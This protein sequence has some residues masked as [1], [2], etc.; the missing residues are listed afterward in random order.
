MSGIGLAIL[1]ILLLE[2]SSNVNAL[3]S[4]LETENYYG[5]TILSLS[6]MTYG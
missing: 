1:C 2:S 5:F 3:N 4:S 6:N